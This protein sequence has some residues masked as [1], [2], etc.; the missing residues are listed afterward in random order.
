MQ[1]T[2]KR[3][4]DLVST[5]VKERELAFEKERQELLSF[6]HQIPNKK[7][8]QQ[9]AEERAAEANEQREAKELQ[10]KT[11]F[12]KP[13]LSDL[14]EKRECMTKTIQHSLA[15][16][17]E[18][19]CKTNHLDGSDTSNTNLDTSEID[20]VIDEIPETQMVSPQ[21][22]A[23]G[24]GEQCGIGIMIAQNAAAQYVVVNMFPTVCTWLLVV[25][26][27]L[28]CSWLLVVVWS[29]LVFA[30]MTSCY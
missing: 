25:V 5:N 28:V 19:A 3:K 22:E 4:E 11:A 2:E 17:E 7:K 30:L 24:A 6:E 18:P 29:C 9:M 14:N 27:W 20:Y 21:K 15:A 23:R 1:A 13:L 10:G 12:D 16:L 8:L 26:V